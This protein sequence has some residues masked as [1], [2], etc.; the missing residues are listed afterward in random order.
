MV[1]F[2]RDWL[3][4]ISAIQAEMGRLLDYFGSSKPPKVY[5]RPGVWEPSVDV[6]ETEEELVVLVE[7][8]GVGEEDIEVVVDNTA[9]VVRGERKENIPG[10]KR[11][12]SQMEIPKGPFQKVILLPV[13]VNPDQARAVYDRGFLE[14]ILPK[15]P[16][17]KTQVVRIKA[18]SWYGRTGGKPW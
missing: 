5:F 17:R 3:F 12:Y 9:L 13:T 4:N 15:V 14:I 18:I 11:I 8:A 16:E 10:G 6:Y 2:P 7:L 1:E